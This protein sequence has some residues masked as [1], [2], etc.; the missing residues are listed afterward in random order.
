MIAYLDS[1]VVL[2][3]I[4]K[5][6]VSI[7]HAF[8]VGRVASSE[9]LEVECRRVIHRCRM[10][11]ELSD[12]GLVSAMDRLEAVLAGLS[13]MEL[14]AKVTR[15]AM[16]AFPVSVKTLDALHL[17]SALALSDASPEETVLVFTHAAAMNRCAKALGFR[18]PLAG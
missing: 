12:E 13:L 10:E 17:S 1:S 15:R 16:N 6:E 11:G 14:S 18:A 5:G 2:R 3:H 7:R 8:A 9:L 4:L